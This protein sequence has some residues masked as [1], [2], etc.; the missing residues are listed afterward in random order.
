MITLR[1]WLSHLLKFF[2][3]ISSDTIVLK[4]NI[5][6]KATPTNKAT[7]TATN[8]ICSVGKLGA[9]LASRPVR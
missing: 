1:T 6:L 2:G 9:L 5:I 4:Y 3:T 7:V 8:G